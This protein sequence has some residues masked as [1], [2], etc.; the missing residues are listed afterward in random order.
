MN[1]SVLLIFVLF[2]GITA[3]AQRWNK[4]RYEALLGIGATNFLGDLGGADQ[5]GTNGLKDLEL[6][7]TRPSVAAG[8]RYRVY[9]HWSVKGLFAWGIVR[10]D[11]KLTDEF[12]RNNRQ[13]HFKSNIYE[14]SFQIE[15]HLIK[16]QPGHRYKI[17]G[18]RG[19]KNIELNVYGFAGIAGLY[20]NPKAKYINGGWYEL[21]PLGT[22]GQGIKPDLDPYS[23]VTIAIPLGIGIKHLFTRYFSVGLEVGMRKTFT[24]YL[25]DVSSTYYTDSIR[26]YYNND[27]LHV[28]FADP[29]LGQGP[30]PRSVWQ[31]QQRGDPTDKDAY[32]F[33]HITM[34]YKLSYKKRTRSKF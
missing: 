18:A 14:L 21:Q 9:E 5:I 30:S 11:D 12:Y 7:L 28:Y 17:K 3:D 4:F 23:R 33:V 1:R 34:A 2:L 20:F 10:G 15:G 25:D 16:E 26:T 13:L 22:E 24:D 8:L 32:M 31:G 29:S 27:P 6:I 19:W